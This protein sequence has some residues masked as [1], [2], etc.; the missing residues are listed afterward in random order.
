[1]K[2]QFYQKKDAEDI[3]NLILP[4]E[5]FYF[6][7]KGDE[8]Y[9]DEEEDE[10]M[11]DIKR[12]IT[13]IKSS[14][15]YYLE[16]EM[17]S[18]FMPIIQDLSEVD[19]IITLFENKLDMVISAIYNAKDK[20]NKVSHGKTCGQ[21]EAWY[22]QCTAIKNKLQ[23]SIE[24]SSKFVW[25]KV[26]RN[27]FNSFGNYL[28]NLEEQ[29]RKT[30]FKQIEVFHE[31]E[32]QEY[33]RWVKNEVEKAKKINQFAQEKFLEQCE[34]LKLEQE[35]MFQNQIKE[36]EIIA[37]ELNTKHLSGCKRLEFKDKS[38]YIGELEDNNLHGK[39]KYYFANGDV[40]EGEFN[41]NE[42]QGYGKIIS[43]NKKYCY[44]GIWKNGLMDKYGLFT[45]LDTG[46]VYKG[47]M[48]YGKCHGEGQL[49]WLNGKRFNGNFVNNRREGHGKLY[50]KDELLKE[51][52]WDNDVLKKA[53]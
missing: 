21:I 7:K 38:Y 36:A 1:M 52:F 31:Q 29:V 12:L 23:L 2:I 51:G 17:L 40:Y 11:D 3:A 32:A 35:G 9:L 47:Q 14:T 15:P 48:K 28:Q 13:N 16:R 53:L 8:E 27:C 43:F 37:E 19:I 34:L 20:F 45:Y 33:E 25:M 5:N 4:D 24:N 18:N 42:I 39:G 46:L 26:D 22:K 44:E 6:Y 41:N 30:L 50:L 49:T 10:E